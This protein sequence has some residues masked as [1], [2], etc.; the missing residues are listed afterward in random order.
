MI[1]LFTLTE[2]MLQLRVHASKP[3]AL[4]GRSTVA[5]AW[6]MHINPHIPITWMY[7]ATEGSIAVKKHRHHTRLV[8][9][10]CSTHTHTHTHTHTIKAR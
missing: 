1:V 4:L 9:I 10:L 5:G 8:H 2:M 3:R 6:I 7:L